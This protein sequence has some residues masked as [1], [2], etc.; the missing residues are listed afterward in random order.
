VNEDKATRYHRLTRRASLL[1]TALGA[2]FLAVLLVT[3]ASAALRNAASSLAGGSFFLTIVIYAALL[4]LLSEALQLPLSLYQELGLERRY[5]LSTQSMAKWWLDWLKGGAVTLVFA[6]VASL[7][8]FSLLRWSPGGWWWLA[9]IAFSAVLIALA[10]LAP[11]LLM[12]LFYEVKPLERAAL[13]DRLVALAERAGA[14]VLGVFEW[15]LSDRTRKA[16]AA[17]AGIG[18]TRRILLSDTL[19]AEHSDDE[20]E[21]ILAHELAHHVYRDIWSGIALE[22]LLILGGFY[23]ADLA[24]TALAGSFGLTGKSDVALTPLL[25]LTAG[26]V[27]LVL[28]PVFNA[29]SR[30]HERRADRYALE[31]TRNVEAFVTAMKR[32]AAQNLAEERPSRLVEVLFYT[33]PPTAARVEAARAW[34]TR[35][36]KSELRS[37]Y[38]QPDRLNL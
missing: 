38:N 1:G 5:G 31:M 10:Q 18:R 6:A 15:R 12:P 4:V 33:H 9:A 22:A 19:L 16:N 7:I 17:L 2:A 29:F 32:L 20:I 14:R 8:V 36:G 25:L 3:G 11:V 24:I 21:V 37:G 34:A 35:T 13:V 27:S 28:M 23:L 26:G 30:A